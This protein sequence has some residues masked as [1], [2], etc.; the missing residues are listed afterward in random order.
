M[1]QSQH[2]A[3]TPQLQQSIRLLQ[4]STIELNRE[5]E[6]ILAQNPLLERDD[7]PQGAVV[8]LHN[9]GSLQPATGNE[10]SPV[11]PSDAAPRDDFGG[12]AGDPLAGDPGVATG[13]QTQPAGS[14]GAEA[15]DGSGLDLAQA[16][17]LEAGAHGGSDDP[18]DDRGKE[19]AAATGTSLREHLMQ[20]LA[21]ARCTTRDRALVELLIDELEEDGYLR[22]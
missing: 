21:G 12:A 6:Q 9:D 22:T 10:G 19:H 14:D 17:S 8:R 7:D 3:L 4:L 20:Q 18:D 16:W 13:A 11:G 15:M 2:L 1:R 5:I